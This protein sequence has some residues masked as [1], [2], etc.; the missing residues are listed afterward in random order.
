MKKHTKL[1]ALMLAAITV[2]CLLAA[3]GGRKQTE[4]GANTDPSTSATP[5]PAEA[6]TGAPSG[7]HEEPVCGGE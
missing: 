3:C 7:E 4:E 6:S 2:L 1:I 5:A